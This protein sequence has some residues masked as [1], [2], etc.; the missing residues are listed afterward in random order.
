M[1][2]RTRLAALEDGSVIAIGGDSLGRIARYDPTTSTWTT[3]APTGA[4]PV[5]ID[6]PVTN[7]EPSTVLEVD[8][9]DVT[10]IREGQGPLDRLPD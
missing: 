6:A 2:S 7:S 3:P 9:D 4:V 5:V 1:V 8:G 10:V